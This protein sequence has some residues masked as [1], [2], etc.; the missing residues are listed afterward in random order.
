M[1]VGG[2]FA[3]AEGH[4]ADFGD[5]S[6]FE[7]VHDGDEF[8]NGE[9]EVGANDDSGV[10]VFEFGGKESGFEVLSGDGGVVE[11]VGVVFVDR[12]GEDLGGVHGALRGGAFGDDEVEAVLDKGG[13]DHKDDQEHEGEIEQGGDIQLGEG[14]EVVLRGVAPHGSGLAAAGA[15][16]HE[17]VFDL[18]GEFGG[19][20][21][22]LDEHRAH[23]GDEE[24]VAEH[25]GDGD[26]EANDGG[27]EGA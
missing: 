7:D 4:D 8:L 22:G 26:E 6:A 15:E 18:G 10:G 25:G 9:L 5:A 13:G 19:E 12:D 20:V 21:V 23:G 17:A 16:F 24:V 11:F 3:L 27:D 1:S 2:G 14:L